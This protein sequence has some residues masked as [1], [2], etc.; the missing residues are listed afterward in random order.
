MVNVV[1]IA[2]SLDVNDRLGPNVGGRPALVLYS[3]DEPGELLQ[4][5]CY[6]NSTMKYME[7]RLS[8]NPYTGT[9]D[10]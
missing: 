3:S 6:D 10:Y 4:W 7:A 8:W 9:H 1:T 5:Q 2:A